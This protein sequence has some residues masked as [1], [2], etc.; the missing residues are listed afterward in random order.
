[1]PDSALTKPGD[2]VREEL[3][4]SAPLLPLITGVA[5]DVMEATGV[6]PFSVG[7]RRCAGRLL[8]DA[9][10]VPGGGGAGPLLIAGG[11]NLFITLLLN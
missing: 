5:A 8:S 10:A 1:M 3:A 6:G 11:K 4:L 7:G 2:A 9:V